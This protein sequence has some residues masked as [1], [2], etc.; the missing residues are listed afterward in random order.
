M[1]K[2]FDQVKH[3]RLLD[4]LR[5]IGIRGI[6][7]SWFSSYLSDRK[8]KGKVGSALSTCTHCTRGVPQGSVLGTLFFILYTKH[9]NTVLPAEVSHQEFA[10]DIE[11]DFSHGDPQVVATT[12]FVAVS[13][14]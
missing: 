2:A 3:A 9:I 7:L 5:S 12:L 6:A 1:S 4:I 13:S 11:L 14:L 10:D 8:Q